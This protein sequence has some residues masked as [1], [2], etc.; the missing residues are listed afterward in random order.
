[1]CTSFHI[2][3]Q[4]SCRCLCAFSYAA[5]A[6]HFQGTQQE[7]DAVVGIWVLT[8]SVFTPRPRVRC[9]CK[10]EIKNG[11]IAMIAITAFAV[12][13]VVSSSGCHW[14]NCFFKLL[15]VSKLI[16][17]GPPNPIIP[18]I[19]FVQSLFSLIIPFSW[20]ESITLT[21]GCCKLLQNHRNGRS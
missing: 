9:A 3:W 13:E 1:L 14:W 6:W 15:G 4:E 20:K 21:L 18:S 5:T 2:P 16:S 7:S 11:R 10:H 8:L 12:Q 19:W 17:L